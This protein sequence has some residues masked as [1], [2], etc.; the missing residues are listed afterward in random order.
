[1]TSDR[2][3]F[4]FRPAPLVVFATLAFACLMHPTGAGAIGPTGRVSGSVRGRSR[5]RALVLEVEL[6]AVA[7][8]GGAHELIDRASTTTT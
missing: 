3:K 1:M 4:R 8:H 6:V 7:Q 5:R 2:V